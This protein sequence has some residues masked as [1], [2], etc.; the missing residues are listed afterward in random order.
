MAEVLKHMNA[1]AAWL[2]AVTLLVGHWTGDLF[3]QAPG[4]N[5]YNPA[6]NN[7]FYRPTISPY[8]NLLRGGNPAVNYYL[9]VVPEVERRAEDYRVNQEILYLQRRRTAT[10]ET[11]EFLPTLAETGHPAGFMTLAPYYTFGNAFT[12]GGSLSR[13]VPSTAA[14]APSGRRSR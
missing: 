3:G 9:G 13:S 8:L 2:S 12:A 6:A 11:E 14:P 4:Y 1:R 7:P 5:R 10:P